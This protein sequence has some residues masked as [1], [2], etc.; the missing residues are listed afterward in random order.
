LEGAGFRFAAMREPISHCPPGG[1][2]RERRW[3]WYS[4]VEVEPK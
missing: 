1:K 3:F 2:E 4:R